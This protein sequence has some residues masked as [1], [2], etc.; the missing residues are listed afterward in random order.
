MIHLIDKIVKWYADC[1][2][3]YA[4]VQS[5]MYARQKLSCHL[6]EMAA[7]VTQLQAQRNGAEF[8]RKAA[9]AEIL[10]REMSVEKTTAAAAKIIADNEV[11]PEMEREMEC[12]SEYQKARLL[13]DAYRNVCDVMNQH[14]SCLKAEK[15]NEFIGS[16]SQ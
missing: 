15:R 14:I 1:P 5:L 11:R 9:H 12:D 8:Q 3:D 13:Y 10:R 4:D 2:K 7:Q 6:A 16:G